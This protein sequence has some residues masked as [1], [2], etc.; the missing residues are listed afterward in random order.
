MVFVMWRERYE[1]L[2]KKYGELNFHTLLSAM[3]AER[4][5]ETIADRPDWRQFNFSHTSP[6]LSNSGVVSL[7]LLAY[8]RLPGDGPLTLEEV[9]QPDFRRWV[10]RFESQVAPLGQQLL[11]STGTLMRTMVERGPSS[12]D[13]VLVYENLAIENFKAAAGRFGEIVVVYP[14]ENLWNENPY[15]VLDVPWSSDAQQ[16][17]AR[18]FLDFLMSEAVQRRAIDH[19][20]R[21]GNLDVPIRFA[22][23]PFLKHAP[24]GIRIDVTGIRPAPSAE[25]LRS[26]LATFDEA[27]R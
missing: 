1:L 8:H 9:E 22:G 10:K 27:G 19:G 6:Q 17:A 18:T 7:V 4:G 2:K 15:Y 12:Y 23:S 5:W 20:F 11:H 14:E 3:E 24:A 26:L 25:V 16:A 13:C 21:P